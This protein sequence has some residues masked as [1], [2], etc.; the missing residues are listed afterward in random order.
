MYIY[1]YILDYIIMIYHDLSGWCKLVSTKTVPR[2]MPQ[3]MARSF[4]LEWNVKR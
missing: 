4:E 2:F 1:I 3:M